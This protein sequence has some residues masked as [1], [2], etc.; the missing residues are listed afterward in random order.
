MQ[1]LK[2]HVLVLAEDAAGIGPALSAVGHLGHV[3]F[4]FSPLFGYHLM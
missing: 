4:A 3:L 2:L 1:D